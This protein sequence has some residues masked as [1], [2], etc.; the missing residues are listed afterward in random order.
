M[1]LCHGPVPWNKEFCR[2][3]PDLDDDIEPVDE[4]ARPASGRVGNACSCCCKRATWDTDG[5][6]TDC[7][8]AVALSRAWPFEIAGGGDDDAD[9]KNV[10][11]SGIDWGCTQ[12]QPVS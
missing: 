4:P 7:F 2:L 11:N 9:D 12:G 1:S 3:P 6:D 5:S 10:G 8:L